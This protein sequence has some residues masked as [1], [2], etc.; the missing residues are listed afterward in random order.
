[1][2]GQHLAH[3]ALVDELFQATKGRGKA[4]LQSHHG[5]D[6]LSLGQIGH[7]LCFA[8]VR[9]Q[10][11]FGE[12]MLSGSQ[13]VHGQPVME[14][15]AY[16]HRYSIDVGV[17]QHFLV[18]VEGE[19]HPKLLGGL[20]GRLLVRRTHPNELIVWQ[21]G[22]GWQVGSTPPAIMHIGA[23]NADANLSLCH[24]PLLSCLRLSIPTTLKIRRVRPCE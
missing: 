16:H 10:G 18:V 5:V 14:W 19:R 11:P 1:M 24:G 4:A 6:P 15:H 7:L 2:T 3:I 17:A 9:A 20:L 22:Q 12:D 23:N 8:E 21:M 13:C